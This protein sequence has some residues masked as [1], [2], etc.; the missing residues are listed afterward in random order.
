MSLD[1]PSLNPAQLDAVYHLRGPCLVIAGA[2]SGKTRVITHKL[3]AL[4]QSKIEPSQIAAIT[5]TNKAANEMRERAKQLVGGKLSRELVICTFH[6]L[7]VRLL[8]AEG[9]AVGLKPSFSIL[10]S[11]DQLNLIKDASATTDN[12]LARRMQW[13]ISG[14]KNANMAPEAAEREA[15]QSNN[16]DL[17]QAAKVYARYNAQ[18]AAYQSCDFDDLILLPLKLFE[19]NPDARARWQAKLRYLLV[20]EYQDT[21]STQYELLK[22][23]VGDAGN[24]T[25]VG[26]DDQSIY[27]WRG[28]TLDN[29][30][31]VGEDYPTLRVIKLEQNY[32]S[33]GRILHAANSV[34]GANPK[35]YDKKLWSALG[36]GEAVELLRCDTED[37]EAE[38][39]AAR[40]LTHRATNASKWADYAV[41]YRANYLSRALEAALRKSQIP[42]VVSGGQSFFERAEIRD[43]CAYLRLLANQDD[44]PAFIRAITTP[45]RGIGTATL[46][47]LGNFASLW[48]VS[49]FEAL[50]MDSC[51]ASLGAKAAEHLREFGR[52]I[53]DIEYRARTASAGD[54][55]N[56]LL[57][58]IGYEK[59]L[60]DSAE[61]DKQAADK[62]QNVLDFSEWLGKKAEED[63]Q[64]LVQM[65]QMIS[66]ITQL[67]ERGEQRDAVTLST[68]HAAKGLEWPSVFI[69]GAEDGLL[70]FYTDDRPL[71][72][73]S[74]QEERRLM[75][76]AI[77]RARSALV[78]TT[79]ARRKRG[80]ELR[81]TKPSR[82]IAEMKLDEERAKPASVNDRLARL[83][84]SLAKPA[85]EVTLP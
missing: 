52:Y 69:A 37:H 70:P 47:K 17:L 21:N 39:I 20:D 13:A 22:H 73:S 53:N 14:W 64:T 32:R 81:G 50:F 10:D 2:G 54:L 68:I 35:L 25:A 3:Q 1:A 67:Q 76:V 24:F 7:G 48:K 61:N 72:D 44:D 11:D 15:L 28:A 65:S 18:L 42:Y 45:K 43:I 79:A 77:T 83:K 34:I 80:R 6:A 9:E 36:E 33:T 46:E 78:L 27:G 82:F 57:K 71:N 16:V 31:R 4:L 41:L 85:P 51:A 29:L 84:A 56:D 63:Q 59:H 30:K 74:L 49:L 5:F 19:Q 60:Y 38:R 58:D 12:K 40:I 55:L 8:R 23:L 66:L 62:W 75:Y 26:D